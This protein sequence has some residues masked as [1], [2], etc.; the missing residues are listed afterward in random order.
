M[1]QRFRLNSHAAC[2]QALMIWARIRRPV[3]WGIRGK[4]RDHTDVR[5]V[6][7]NGDMY[8]EGRV[9]GVQM[10]RQPLFWAG[11]ARRAN[12]WTQV[13]QVPPLPCELRFA[14]ATVI[15]PGQ[16]GGITCCLP[17]FCGRPPAGVPAGRPAPAQPSPSRPPGICGGKYPGAPGCPH[18]HPP[19]ACSR[20]SGRPGWGWAGPGAHGGAGPVSRPG[21]PTSLLS[22]DPAS[23]R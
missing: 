6:W 8:I 15:L 7:F 22:P 23:T 14:V 10:P 1:A 19:S 9:E 20:G 5:C 13:C 21:L 11:Y 16:P 12:Q 3:R 17:P 2:E 18:P 4:M